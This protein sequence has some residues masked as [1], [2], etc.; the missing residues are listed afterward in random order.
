[1]PDSAAH[2]WEPPTDEQLERFVAVRVFGPGYPA[3]V[4]NAVKNALSDDF[5]KQGWLDQHRSF[6][7]AAWNL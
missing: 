3:E 6:Q 5:V 2:Q 7:E 1:M 4:L